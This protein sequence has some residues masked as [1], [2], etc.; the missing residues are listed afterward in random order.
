MLIHSQPTTPGKVSIVLLRGPA[1]NVIPIDCLADSIAN[2]G[3]F[4][5]SPS[6]ALTPDVT[7]Y[8]LQIIVTGTGQF[9]YSTQFGISNPEFVSSKSASVTPTVSKPIVSTPTIS[10]PTISKPIV[11]TP[12]TSKPTTS[13]PTISKPVS[14]SATPKTG[15]HP[16]TQIS[17]GQVQVPTSVSSLTPIVPSL[18]PIPSANSTST[19]YKPTGTGT[20]SIPSHGTSVPQSTTRLLPTKSMT[21]PYSLK[22]NTP[23][24]SV[25]VA[26]SKSG[27]TAGTATPIT[28]NPNAAGRTFAASALLG[29][30]GMMVAL[31]V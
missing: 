24:Q 12:T 6:T 7:H 28:A 20:A 18:S 22:P 27:S 13:T 4:S 11:S 14:S 17:D 1:E 26:T 3:T 23:T 8:G 2:T 31:L 21:I 29:T 5:W 9:Q 15:L 25:P 16:I 30:L 19:T 10:T